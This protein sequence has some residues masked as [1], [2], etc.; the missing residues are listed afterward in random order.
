MRFTSSAAMAMA[1]SLASASAVVPASPVAERHLLDLDLGTPITAS[2]DLGLDLSGRILAVGALAGVSLDPLA[3]VGAL[4]NVDIECEE[5]YTK[6]NIDASVDLSKIVPSLSL[7]LTDIEA[8]LD[9]DISIDA[10]ALIHV[11]LVTPDVK[12]VIPLPGLKVEA[13]VYLDLILAVEAGLDL[14]AGVFVQ[15]VDEA[16]LN[17]DIFGGKILE[18]AFSGLAV[19]VLPIEVRV[20]CTQLL[21]D[22]QLRVELGIAAEVDVDDILP[23]DQLLGLDLPSIGAGVDL[24]VYA[25]LVEYL[26]FFCATPL[27][28][29]SKESWG[30]NVGVAL[31]VD[32]DIEDILSLHLVPTISTALLA[33]PTSTICQIP[34][35]T[36]SAPV[37][38][39]TATTS[40]SASATGSS[41][42]AASSTAAGSGSSSGA[43]SSTAAGSGS[44]TATA[45]ATGTGAGYPSSTGAGNGTAA[46]PTTTAAPSGGQ[47]TSTVTASTT[48]TITNCGVAVPNCPAHYQTE[49]TYIHTTVYTTICPATMTAPITGYPTKTPPAVTTTVVQT[50]V[51]A[52]PTSEVNTFTA[53]SNAPTYPVTS[54]VKPSVSASYPVGSGSVPPVAM[55]TVVTPGGPLYPT[56]GANGTVPA[57]TGLMT[58]YK[59]SS[60]P[61]AYLPTSTSAYPTT[62]APAETTPVTAGAAK[63]GS[64]VAGALAVVAAV[65]AM[66]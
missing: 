13:Y 44:A 43:A 57:S 9:L 3:E 7:S 47:I 48:L 30:L 38:T 24:A 31:E 27:C 39:M 5:C 15:L 42:G 45:T 11:N 29:K 56:G 19:Q 21:A 65:A 12:L 50:Y 35:S 16:S 59:P 10:A 37:S 17:V 63:I 23:L 20:G 28:P 14:S 2:I 6:G 1:A 51:T 52:V 36:G 8:K 66:L 53:P 22:L 49:T 62:S 32:V 25:N 46:Y 34:S 40:A 64:G 33:N 58:T 61:S 41:S 18:A 54:P 26:G 60:S 4:V 55:P